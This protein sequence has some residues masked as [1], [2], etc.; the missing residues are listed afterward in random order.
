M[1]LKIVILINQDEKQI[2]ATTV[3]LS[4]ASVLSEFDTPKIHI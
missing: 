1:I 2:E 3:F 4:S